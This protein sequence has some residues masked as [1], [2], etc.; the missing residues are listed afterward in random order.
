MNPREGWTDDRISDRFAGIDRELLEQHERLN[1]HRKQLDLMHDTGMRIVAL[2]GRVQM[3]AEDTVECR[4][5]IKEL[6]QQQTSASEKAADALQAT[7]DSLPS[8]SRSRR[9]TGRCASSSSRPASRSPG[10]C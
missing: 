9:M 8:V 4:D 10:C 7:A 5:G 6:R 2:D 3:I 1:A